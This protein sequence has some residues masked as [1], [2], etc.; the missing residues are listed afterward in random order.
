MIVTV[1]SSEKGN[2]SVGGGKQIKLEA[3]CE[4]ACSGEVYRKEPTG[5]RDRYCTYCCQKNRALP[6]TGQREVWRRYRE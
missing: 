2:S 6:C 4:K 1:K 5:C 3:L